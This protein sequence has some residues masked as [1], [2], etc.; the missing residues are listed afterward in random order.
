GR[1]KA[2]ERIARPDTVEAVAKVFIERHCLRANRPR[3]A[4]ETERLLDLHVLPR[5]R[6]RL[7]RDITRRDVLDLLDR[8]V[9]SGKP[10]AANRVLSATRKMFNWAVGRDI[11]AASPCSGVKPP[12]PETSR[13][14]VLA[15]SE[16]RAV[17]HAADK[18]GGPYGALVKLL[19]LTGQRRD[20]VAGV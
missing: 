18:I 6:S 2:H 19:I 10:I 3:T 5:W 7:I 8:V 11:I 13:D 15:D 9:D 12:S 16:L 17:W 20:E 1:E 14:R 4:V